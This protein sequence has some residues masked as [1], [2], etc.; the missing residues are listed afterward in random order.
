MDHSNSAVKAVLEEYVKIPSGGVLFSVR[1][2]DEVQMLVGQEVMVLGSKFKIKTPSVFLN[3]FYLDVSVVHTTDETNE[4]F[5]ALCTLGARPFSTSPR[6][7]PGSPSGNSNV[8]FLLRL[9]SGATMLASPW[10]CANQLA[11]GLHYYMAHGKQSLELLYIVNLATQLICVPTDT[12]KALRGM[13]K[14]RYE[15]LRRKAHH[16]RQTQNRSDGKF[17]R[18]KLK[19]VCLFPCMREH[20]MGPLVTMEKSMTLTPRLITQGR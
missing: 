1:S 19:T 14:H 13:D 3:K 6:D 5:L 10:I 4:L 17:L 8:A 15:L 16:V 2:L 11:F 20:T 12:N 9:L 7:V 18:Q